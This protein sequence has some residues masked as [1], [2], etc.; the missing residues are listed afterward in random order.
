MHII[1]QQTAYDGHYK[2]SQL[3]VQDGDKVL[4]RERFEPGTA[5]AALV[6]HTGSGDEMAGWHH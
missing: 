6:R 2:L 3:R 1:D 5:V 4:K